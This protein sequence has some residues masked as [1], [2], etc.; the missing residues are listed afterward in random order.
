MTRRLIDIDTDIVIESIA[1]I[2]L[3]RSEFK[4]IV[5]KMVV[6][7]FVAANRISHPIALK[8]IN[9]YKIAFNLMIDLYL[10]NN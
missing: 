2:P 9:N 1:I 10:N 5:F 7:Q 4:I 3:R 6:R 8:I